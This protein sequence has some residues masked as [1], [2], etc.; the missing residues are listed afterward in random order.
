MKTLFALTLM[1]FSM[2]TFAHPNGTYV[3]NGDKEVTLTI[4]RLNKCVAAPGALSGYMRSF[5]FSDTAKAHPYAFVTG[6]Y[7]EIHEG[8]KEIYVQVNDAC[9]PEVDG[10]R[11]EASHQTFDVYSIEKL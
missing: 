5:I 1:A 9:V 2:G 7:V 8:S 3:I 4:E 10:Q 6:M 11:Y